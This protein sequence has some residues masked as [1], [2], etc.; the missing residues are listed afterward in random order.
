M[1]EKPGINDGVI[2]WKEMVS[3]E[4]SVDGLV[5]QPANRVLG[6]Q[7]VAWTRTERPSKYMCTVHEHQA[8]AHLR[9][10]RCLGVGRR[11]VQAV[12]SSYR[13]PRLSWTRASCLP[14]RERIHAKHIYTHIPVAGSD[15]SYPPAE[16][17][18]IGG[19][20]GRNGRTLIAAFAV[21]VVVVV[22]AVVVVVVQLM[23]CAFP[24][25]SDL[26]GVRQSCSQEFYSFRVCHRFET[27]RM[28][29][30]SI[31]KRR[32]GTVKIRKI[33]G[34][35]RVADHAALRCLCSP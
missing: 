8:H 2:S 35:P 21:A 25:V 31:E 20:L 7:R 22:G 1:D 23:A 18:C 32:A 19:K 24:G 30:T 16:L 28:N 15:P 12:H 13:V 33:A 4:S 26:P 17:Y 5:A 27:R 3:A 34:S 10:Q 6:F 9:G 14:E 29:V 11:H